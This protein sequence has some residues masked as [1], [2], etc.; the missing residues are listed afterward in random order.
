MLSDSN[1][2]IS[3][4]PDH[5]YNNVSSHHMCAIYNIMYNI[6]KYIHVCIYIVETGY[7]FTCA[8]N[9]MEHAC[10]DA[11]YINVCTDMLS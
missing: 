9:N 10:I 6:Y 2:F 3:V 5:N 4:S 11:L 1:H 7:K 8:G